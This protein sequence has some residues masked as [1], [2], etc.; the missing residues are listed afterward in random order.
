[1][2]LLPPESHIPPQKLKMINKMRSLSYVFPFEMLNKESLMV[3]SQFKVGNKKVKN[4]IMI[5]KH[6][7]KGKEIKNFEFW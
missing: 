1:M 4:L 6:Y 2:F 5:E 3:R 7:Y